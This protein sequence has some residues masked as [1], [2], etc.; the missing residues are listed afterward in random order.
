[1]IFK[2]R[3]GKWRFTFTLAPVTDVIGVNS[4]IAPNK[5]ILMWD[6]DNT[7]LWA[8]IESLTKVQKTYKLPRIYILE[9]KKDTNYIAYCFKKVSWRK[10]CEILAYTPNID[11]SYYRFGVYRQQFTLRVTPKS[12]RKPTLVHIIPSNIAEDAYITD[13]KSWVKYETLADNAVKFLKEV[14]IWPKN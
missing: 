1:M 4:K 7:P 14:S 2:I 9:T 5:H 6:F 3:I 13:L 12:G 10:C 8:V 11:L